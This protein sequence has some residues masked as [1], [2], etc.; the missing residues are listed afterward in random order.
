MPIE[1]IHH[2]VA[3]ISLLLL[4]MLFFGMLFVKTGQTLRVKLQRSAWFVFVISAAIATVQA[5][6]VRYVDANATGRHTGRDWENAYTGITE[7]VEACARAHEE[8]VV[9]V[10]PGTYGCIWRDNSSYFEER[11]LYPIEVY[12][13]EGP[14]KTFIAG[15]GSRF[16][17]GVSSSYLVP[18]PSWALVLHGITFVDLGCAMD[19]FMAVGCVISNCCSVANCA[20]LVD[21]LITGNGT[22]GM[23]YMFVDCS[24]FGCTVVGN[25]EDDDG[26]EGPM[27]GGCK[28]YNSIVYSNELAEGHCTYEFCC[29]NDPWFVDA[30]HG[31]YHLAMGS[32]CIN[33][34][35]NALGS[36]M[37]DLDGNPRVVRAKVDIGCYEFQPT[38]ESQTITAP[39]PV[40]F[41]WV[42]EKCP[43]ILASVDGDYD[44]AVLQRSANPIDIAKPL[45]ER[46]YFTVWESYVADL[47][48]TDSNMTFKAV[49]DFA[50][51]TPNVRGDPLSPRRKYTV[52]GKDSL[53]NA[54]WNAA[55]PESR[56][57]KVKVSLP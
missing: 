22:A 49:I 5:Q 47:D 15:D 31:D 36:G 35:E 51:G 1:Q 45:A 24:L 50:D 42:A 30:A 52:L 7:A 55:G 25:R 8:G 37:S 34:G 38:N 53:T 40:E 4:A 48:P 32:P 14:S 26:W 13:I 27:F 43:D 9:Y 6:K 23:G 57:F 19:G 33:A 10:R 44:R 20:T 46:M 56:F 21:C 11:W 2:V 28:A 18:V 39:V 16:E 17:I 3:G 29:T 41:S 54:E 12:A